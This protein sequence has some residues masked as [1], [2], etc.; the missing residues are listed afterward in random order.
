M[1][2][3]GA[4]LIADG[5]VTL[6]SLLRGQGYATAMVGKAVLG[7]DSRHLGQARLDAAGEGYAAG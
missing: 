6:A 7:M 1:G 2:A 5:R 4:C 3:E